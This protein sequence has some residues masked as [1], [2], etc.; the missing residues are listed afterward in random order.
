M[1]FFQ[2]MLPPQVQ[3]ALE[4]LVTSLAERPALPEAL[5]ALWTDHGA[6]PELP[7][8]VVEAARS[9]D[10]SLPTLTR[11]T[12]GVAQLAKALDGEAGPILFA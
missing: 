1:V 6:D 2:R 12:N 9:F 11:T 10:R 8:D 7:D 5:A 3:K 4:Q